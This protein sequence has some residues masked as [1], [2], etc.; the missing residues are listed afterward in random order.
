[1][2]RHDHAIDAAIHRHLGLR[3][4]Q[5]AL[6]QQRPAPDLAQLL[7]I[8]PGHRGIEQRRH[9]AGDR[10]DVSGLARPHI[11]TEGDAP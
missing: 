6:E 2:V 9:A 3:R 8:L 7:N 5:H 10:A 4:M 11:I 1:M